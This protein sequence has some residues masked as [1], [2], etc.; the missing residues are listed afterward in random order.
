MSEGEVDENKERS[1]E[2]KLDNAQQD[3]DNDVGPAASNPQTSGP[4]EK[5]R[6]AA[7]KAEDKPEGSR[8]PA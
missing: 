3:Q 6:D 8:E 5:V 7:A 4:T 1:N 2:R